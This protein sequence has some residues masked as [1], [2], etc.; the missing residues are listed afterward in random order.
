MKKL[1]L[2]LL[3]TVAWALPAPVHAE[4]HTVTIKWMMPD[5][6]DIADYNVY[7][8]P[9][10]DMSGKLILGENLKPVENPPGTYTLTCPEVDLESNKT[11]YFTVVALKTD[12]TE[13]P[14]DTFSTTYTEAP[15]P[16]P[17]QDF[18]REGTEP[19]NTTSTPAND[20]LIAFFKMETNG[21][22][23]SDQ[24]Y[25]EITHT[26]VGSGAS[27]MSF[28]PGFTGNCI[29]AEKRGD[30]ILLPYSI[31]PLNDITTLSF[32][33]KFD[34]ITDS[35]FPIGINKIGRSNVLTF[36]MNHFSHGPRLYYARNYQEWIHYFDPSHNAVA[37]KWLNYKIIINFPQNYIE[38]LKDGVSIGKWHDNDLTLWQTVDG[39]LRIGFYDSTDP[40][41]GFYVDE[42][43][44][45]R[46]EVR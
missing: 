2:L 14:S 40:N 34:K 9:N 5:T 43:K 24:L 36:N 22:L 44:I 17:V 21:G 37:K 45:Y 46:G 23:K 12:N 30:V 25:D 10:L 38:I 35:Q 26:W 16:G 4:S 15:P 27:S 1:L 13:L 42:V 29:K 28:A 39:D 32:Y 11:Y 6:S 3:L 41:A 20:G 7:Y 8:S 31:L 33:V 19:T 18:R